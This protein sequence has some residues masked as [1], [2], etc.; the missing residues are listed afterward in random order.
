MSV[1]SL[2]SLI[3]RCGYKGRKSLRACAVFSVINIDFCAYSV[4]LFYSFSSPRAFPVISTPAFKHTHTYT[5]TKPNYLF[6]C[7]CCLSVRTP[8]NHPSPQRMFSGVS[9]DP[10]P[11]LQRSGQNFHFL[12]RNKNMGLWEP[13]Q[14]EIEAILRGMWLMLYW[15][16]ITSNMLCE[17]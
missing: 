8:S 15:E 3:Y 11:L 1:L 12:M 13:L 5:H 16:V 6:Y 9:L 7:R 17:C 4:L 10:W 2:L 14:C